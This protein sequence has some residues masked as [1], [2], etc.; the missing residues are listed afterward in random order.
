MGSKSPPEQRFADG[1][2]G[3]MLPSISLPSAAMDPKAAARAA[4][5]A[6]A[7]AKQKQLEAAAMVTNN[8]ATVAP[9]SAAASARV[10][11]AQDAKRK[12]QRLEEAAEA[13]AAE[14]ARLRAQQA[15]IQEESSRRQR[16]KEDAKEDAMN[17]A[18]QLEHAARA[19]GA[20][21]INPVNA[22]LPP[23]LDPSPLQNRGQNISAHPQT[24]NAPQQQVPYAEQN[25][26]QQPNPVMR[27]GQIERAAAVRPVDT[28]AWPAI[29]LNT[30]H[31][32]ASP[33]LPQNVWGAKPSSIL[34]APPPKEEKQP[35]VQQQKGPKAENGLQQKNAWGKVTLGRAAEVKPGT[36]KSASSSLPTSTQMSDSKEN[37]GV[38]IGPESH[39]AADWAVGGVLE[40]SD[41]EGVEK[42]QKMLQDFLLQRNLQNEGQNV[43]CD[44]WSGKNAHDLTEESN[45]TDEVFFMRPINGASMHASIQDPSK[46][47]DAPLRWEADE[48]APKDA[49]VKPSAWALGAPRIAN[50]GGNGA[51]SDEFG[52]GSF[53][54]NFGQGFGQVDCPEGLMAFE[55]SCSDDGDVFSNMEGAVPT[56]SAWGN[57][58]LNVDT[59]AK[60]PDGK[61]GDVKSDEEDGADKSPSV[62]LKMLLGI[63]LGGAAT[64]SQEALP[65]ARKLPVWGKPDGKM[66]ISMDP[67]IARIAKDMPAPVRET[68]EPSEGN[69]DVH[70]S[71][72]DS[73]VPPRQHADAQQPTGLPRH[74]DLGQGFMLAVPDLQ[75]PSSF[76]QA[77]SSLRQ[78]GN[79]S[80]GNMP[81]PMPQPMQQEEQVRSEFHT[82]GAGGVRRMPNMN[83]SDQDQSMREDRQ[84]ES[85]LPFGMGMGMGGPGGVGLPPHMQGMQNPFGMCMGAISGMGGMGRMGGFPNAP[86]HPGDSP[87][88]PPWMSQGPGG[89]HL[90]MGM[91]P[92]SGNHVA[93]HPNLPPWMQPRPMGMPA[94]AGMGNG[95]PPGVGMKSM[96]SV[97]PGGNMEDLLKM[98]GGG[99]PLHPDQPP[100]NPFHQGQMNSGMP[101]RL[102][103]GQ[104]PAHMTPGAPD[105]NF[106][107]FANQGAGGAG[108][109]G[110]G[111]GSNNGSGGGGSF[112]FNKVFGGM[113]LTGGN[114]LQVPHVDGSGIPG[115]VM[116]LA[117]VFVLSFDSC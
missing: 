66:D 35:F 43:P 67:A 47:Q 39:P 86:S 90:P 20:G 5:A 78:G 31:S 95:P 46:D 116:S 29:K 4:A 104:V 13:E 108:G 73:S 16:L 40:G 42:A 19:Q 15:A 12:Q 17:R 8:V 98:L 71:N 111:D 3:M 64:P 58:N 22:S 76:M 37:D 106:N 14:Q 60:E 36:V 91:L 74:L 65:V 28:H 68:M 24:H 113:G 87:S 63:G 25:A 72:H 97:G 69:A 109:A 52:N 101:S 45:D 21:G 6:A 56:K 9:N 110:G 96:G 62:A 1:H 2:A 84:H 34:Q 117:G 85:M 57:R 26:V 30:P 79:L 77:N 103:P 27:M 92:N 61:E 105:W 83:S 89:M 75:G 114:I 23:S 81:M 93:E 51:F 115:N 32:P 94:P 48:N 59:S 102:M 11:A 10:Q 112:D 54:Q 70:V 107:S 38:K 88:M 99:P 100:A 53:G 80:G 55:L 50:R 49:P 44:S 41:P 82:Q 33:V 18:V 7:G